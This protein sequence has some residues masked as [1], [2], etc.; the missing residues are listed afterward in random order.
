MSDDELAAIVDEEVA[1]AAANGAEGGKA[2][3]MVI[4][5]VRERAGGGADGGRDRRAGEVEAQRLTSTS[6][7][8][9]TADRGL[10]SRS[11]SE[12][13]PATS[14]SIDEIGA[15]ERSPARGSIRVH[16][17]LS[18]DH[19]RCASTSPRRGNGV[20]GPAIAPADVEARPESTV[21]GHA[22]RGPRVFG[23]ESET[24]SA[25]VRSTAGLGP[26]GRMRRSPTYQNR[27]PFA[28]RNPRSRRRGHPRRVSR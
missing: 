25:S 11:H 27:E 8:A 24:G 10:S 14:P 21:A 7:R 17:G 16:R 19:G 23:G 5:A 22:D 20:T 9:A 18:D 15:A 13:R 3:G 12:P 4:K 2:M 6:R 26:P 28:T 1:A